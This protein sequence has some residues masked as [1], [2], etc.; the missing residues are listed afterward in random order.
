MVDVQSD[1]RQYQVPPD[2]AFEDSGGFID[3][4]DLERIGGD[5]IELDGNLS[6]LTMVNLVYQWKAEGGS[7]RGW[8]FK[9]PSQWRGKVGAQAGIWIAADHARDQGLTN[10]QVKAL[11]YHELRC[12]GLDDKGKVKVG[13]PEIEAFPDEILRF[14]AWNEPL[15]LAGVVFGQLTNG[16]MTFEPEAG[17]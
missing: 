7:K 13:S 9:V 15:R 6:H 1:A 12:I 16:Q 8:A 11:V 4:P 5:L 3:A 17:V 2:E 14:G 10:H